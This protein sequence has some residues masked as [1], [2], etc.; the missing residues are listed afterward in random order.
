MVQWN[1]ACQVVIL[2]TGRARD[3]FDPIFEE[4]FKKC[5]VAFDCFLFVCFGGRGHFCLLECNA[6]VILL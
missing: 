6:G 5:L 2:S 4:E 3:K 1:G